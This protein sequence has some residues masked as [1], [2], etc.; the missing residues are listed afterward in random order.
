MNK[1]QI[2]EQLDKLLQEL[3]NEND[4]IEFKEYY[5]RYKERVLELNEYLDMLKSDKYLSTSRKGWKITVKGKLFLQRGGYRGQRKRKRIRKF[6]SLAT[7][8][9]AI[10]SV[11]ISFVAFFK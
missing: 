2:E 5:R 11:C 8:I 9:A 7:L 3:N 6:I 1:K 4:S 10:I